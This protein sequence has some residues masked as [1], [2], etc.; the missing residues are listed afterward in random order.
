MKWDTGRQES[1]YFKK[2]ITSGLW[3][4]PFDVYI[5]KFVTGSYIAPHID[6]NEGGKHY[7]I[8]VILKKADAG[9]D[10][11]GEAILNLFNRFI[12]FRPDIM[13]HS[14]SEVTGSRYVLSI[15]W[16]LKTDDAKHVL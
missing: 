9:G 11:E 16:L 12:F 8:N 2:L 14:V 7:R 6:K 15:G 3:P 4:L 1:G 5:L 10:Y 13:E